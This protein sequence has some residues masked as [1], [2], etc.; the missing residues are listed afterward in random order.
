MPATIVQQAAHEP[1]I[2]APWY[3]DAWDDSWPEH[4]PRPVNWN[5]S[6]ESRTDHHG[7]IATNPMI[8]DEA[9]TVIT[10][11][12]KNRWRVLKSVDDLIDS[13]VAL[14]KE[15]GVHDNTYYFYSS[16]HGFQVFS[17]LP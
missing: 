8:T 16:D 2:P 14:C 7:N 6:F 4:E 15:L 11:V 9:A 13:V 12:F 1:F 5:A 17:L 3:L 10:G